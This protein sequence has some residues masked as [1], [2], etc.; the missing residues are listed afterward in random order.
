MNSLKLYRKKL[1]QGFTIIELLI[2]LAIIGTLAAIAIPVFQNYVISAK[3]I[4][5]L[6]LSDS[7]K[8]AV[9]ENTVNGLPFS[10]GWIPPLPTRTVSTDHTGASASVANSG[11]AINDQNGII[12]ITYTDTV[13]LNSPILLLI[14]VDGANLLVPGQLIQ[15]GMVNWECHSAQPPFNDVFTNLTGT[16]NQQFAPASCRN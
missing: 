15:S 6:S 8:A 3:V 1:H 12:T 16:L 4:E 14:P 5:G 7:A 10:N 11:I 9:S 2:V 13:A